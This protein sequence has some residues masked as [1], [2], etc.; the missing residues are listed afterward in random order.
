LACQ[1]I[2]N[3]R[4]NWNW[5]PHFDYADRVMERDFFASGETLSFGGTNW[6]TG[7]SGVNPIPDFQQDMWTS[8]RGSYGNA[9][10]NR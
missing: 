10:W 7:Y 5:Q 1:M 6:A 4:S 8:F 9:I 3:A 2:T